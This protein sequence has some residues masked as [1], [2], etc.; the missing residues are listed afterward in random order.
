[1]RCDDVRN[2]LV[3]YLDGEI[4]AEERERIDSHLANC[5]ACRS[6]MVDFQSTDDLLGALFAPTA[7]DRDIAKEVLTEAK[8]DPWCRHIR[9]ELVAHLDDE[10]T[11]KEKRPV[12]EHLA[13]CCDCR[14]E[15]DGL[16]A[17]GGL[18]DRWTFPAIET[19]LVPLVVP[20]RPRGILRRLMPALAAACILV[21]ATIG[22]I[23]SNGEVDLVDEAIQAGVDPDLLDDP[24]LLDLAE[25]LEWVE[26]IDEVAMVT[27]NG[28]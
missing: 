8:E 14:A 12:A 20:K 23:V 6:E 4:T 16:A 1:M 18:L 11:E 19:D 22:V 7:T 26:K 25:D 15:R 28:G 9:K 13:E 24:N 3:A 21:V 17:S 10:L 5:P 2:D 27:G